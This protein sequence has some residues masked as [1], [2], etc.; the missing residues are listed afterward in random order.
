M[1]LLPLAVQILIPT[2]AEEEAALIDACSRANADEPCV[3]VEVGT[4]DGQMSA[5]V[6]GLGNHRVLVEVQGL[7]DRTLY[8][9]ARLTFLPED[10]PRERARSIGLSVGTLAT[11]LLS[12]EAAPEQSP[13]P[14]GEPSLSEELS[15]DESADAQ[16]ESKDAT[17]AQESPGVARW[18]LHGG[19]GIEWIPSWKRLGP[20]FDLGALWAPGG[21]FSW[22][23]RAALGF[24]PGNA[25]LPDLLHGGMNAGV[26]YIAPVAGSLLVPRL[27]FGVDATNVSVRDS[28][29]AGS[30]QTRFSAASR[31]A[32]AWLVPLS[33]HVRFQMEPSLEFIF[34]P[35]RVYVDEQELGTTGATRFVFR[36]G[37]AWDSMSD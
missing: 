22:G 21:H 17:S 34:S 16:D 30:S 10:D 24:V 5:R 29:Q 33:S 2:S 25:E 11:T 37:A 8:V 19:A 9:S 27:E 36:L 32:L 3:R 4:T 7:E 31:I 20:A 13:A 1:N 6:S 12:G 28:Q 23:L 26:G 15:P 18:L 35:T 14:E